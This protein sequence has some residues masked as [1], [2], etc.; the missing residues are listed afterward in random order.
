MYALLTAFFNLLLKNWLPCLAIALCS[1]FPSIELETVS[2][3]CVAQLSSFFMASETF[4]GFQGLIII[5]IIL[6]TVYAVCFVS[7]SLILVRRKTLNCVRYRM[8]RKTL[9][10]GQR[11]TRV[12]TLHRIRVIYIR[13]REILLRPPSWKHVWKRETCY[14]PFETAPGL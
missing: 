9:N 1:S 10:C 4:V 8:R 5:F 11:R 14:V 6:M 12:W 13:V 7:I 2:V 3:L